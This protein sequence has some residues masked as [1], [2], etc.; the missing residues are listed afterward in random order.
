MGLVADVL[1]KQAEMMRDAT[2]DEML[3]RASLRCFSCTFTPSDHNFLEQSQVLSSIGQIE[4][5]AALSL[6]QSKDDGRLSVSQAECELLTEGTDFSIKTSSNVAMVP[7]LFDDSTETFW[8]ADGQDVA[9]HVEVT[10]ESGS[11]PL[12]EVRVHVDNARDADRKCTSVAVVEPGQKRPAVTEKIPGVFGGWIK[13]ATVHG[14]SGDSEKKRI[15]KFQLEG[16]GINQQD[17]GGGGGR[18]NPRLRGLRLYS[19]PRAVPANAGER[20]TA[21]M[22]RDEARLLFRSLARAVI[23]GAKGGLQVRY[24]ART[25]IMLCAGT[26]TDLY[27]RARAQEDEAADQLPAEGEDAAQLVRAGSANLRE[28]V[29]GLLFASRAEDGSGSTSQSSLSPL[30]TQVG[31]ARIGIPVA[32]FFEEARLRMGVVLYRSVRSSSASCSRRRR[33][34]RP[35]WQAARHGVMTTSVSSSVHWCSRS[36]ARP[37]GC[38]TSAPCRGRWQQ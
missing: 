16:G 28:H 25:V 2:H 19:P 29:V 10:F 35:A 9:M 21:G 32:Q 22:M 30:Q 14:G 33:R 23:F 37:L 15:Y 11:A 8:E 3:I 18:V 17:F 12:H 26:A 6:P 7:S 1:H 31:V 13:L 36:A 5:A 34:C 4:R 38:A 24:I 27:L 20:S